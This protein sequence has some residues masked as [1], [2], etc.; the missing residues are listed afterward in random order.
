MNEEGDYTSPRAGKPPFQRVVF[1]LDSLKIGGAQ[2]H[3]LDLAGLLIRRGHDVRI[4]VY[5]RDLS[6]LDIAA[7]I[8]DRCTVLDFHR[9]FDP[10]GILKVA[11]ELRRFDADIVIA[12]NQTATILA[13]FARIMGVRGRFASI[14]HTTILMGGS[15]DARRF[16]LYRLALLTMDGVIFVSS[17]QRDYWRRRLLFC[18]RA[19][20]VRNGVDVRRFSSIDLA[21]RESARRRLGFND[22]DFVVG[23]SASFRKEKNHS[24]LVESLAALIT[25]KIP[26]K[27]LFLGDGDMRTEV[28]NRVNAMG[29]ADH[30]V[31]AGAQSDVRPFLAALDVGVICSSAVETFSVAALEIMAMGIPMVMSNIGGA[32]EIVRDGVDGALY[33]ANDNSGLTEALMQLTDNDLRRR[34]GALARAGIVARYSDTNMLEGY[35][36]ILEKL[37]AVGR[38]SCWQTSGASP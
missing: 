18:W 14:L 34:A 21:T 37:V 31:F 38:P 7:D 2:R 30:V 23:L 19:W 25:G 10:R 3:T 35:C 13:G 1:V 33:P 6:T 5:A 12:V 16:W 15:W 9:L 24:Q 36:G 22:R 26:A 28:E 4:V 27:L 32:S 8:T 17:K 29:L 20:V 11:S